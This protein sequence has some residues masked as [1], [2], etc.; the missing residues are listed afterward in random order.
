MNNLTKYIAILLLILFTG[1]SL[2]SK[3]EDLST[4]NSY[5]RKSIQWKC[6]KLNREVPLKIY[7]QNGKFLFSLRWINDIHFHGEIKR[8][9][10]PVNHILR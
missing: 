8:L 10:L 6:K 4:L 7:Y 1:L 5:Q 3:A 2:M 9:S